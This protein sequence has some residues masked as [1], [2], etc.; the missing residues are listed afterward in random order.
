MSREDIEYGASGFPRQ[1]EPLLYWLVPVL[2]GMGTYVIWHV[3]FHPVWSRH[4]GTPWSLRVFMLLIG[5][6]GPATAVFLVY[7]IRPILRMGMKLVIYGLWAGV[8]I[9]LLGRVLKFGPMVSDWFW[10]VPVFSLVY[11]LF[12]FGD[13]LVSDAPRTGGP[14]ADCGHRP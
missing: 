10:A 2:V 1:M 5:M 14:H 13:V 7:R 9:S 8:G 11:T 3:L 6:L 4:A 12:I